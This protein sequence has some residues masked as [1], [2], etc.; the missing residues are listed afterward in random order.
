M[1]LQTLIPAYPELEGADFVLADWFEDDAVANELEDLQRSKVL[2]IS[3][4]L[5]AAK[6]AIG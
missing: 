5:G 1:S 2:G 3:A 4:I 6:G